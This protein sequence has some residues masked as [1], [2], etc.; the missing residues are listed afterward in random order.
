[1]STL[2]KITT[3]QVENT[4][5]IRKWLHL[6]KKISERSISYRSLFLVG[7]PLQGVQLVLVAWNV[8][9]KICVWPLG[10][11]M[12]CNSKC[13]LVT[14]TFC[15]DNRGS[16]SVRPSVQHQAS[17][18]LLN[19]KVNQCYVLTSRS[20]IDQSSLR[21]H[22]QHRTLSYVVIRL[23][24]FNHTVFE[25]NV[26]DELK[27]GSS[28]TAFMKIPYPTSPFRSGLGFVVFGLNN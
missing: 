15:L 7:L 2:K 5:M 17:L 24:S 4:L 22:Q 26:Q 23:G 1:M 18:C 28:I 20:S 12:L 8:L 21:V 6:R 16:Q 27:A 10:R 25:I 14:L 19:A 3:A 9:D 13:M 11:L